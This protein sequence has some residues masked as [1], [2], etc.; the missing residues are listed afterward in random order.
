[1]LLMIIVTL[2]EQGMDTPLKSSHM[3]SLVST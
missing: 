1:M 2:R 3:Y